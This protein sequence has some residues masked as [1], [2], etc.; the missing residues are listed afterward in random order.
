[1]ATHKVMIDVDSQGNFSYS[2]PVIVVNPGDKIKWKC[3]KEYWYGIFLKSYFS[4]LDK[5]HYVAGPKKEI[6]ARV[7]ASAPEGTY[8]YGVGVYNK[9]KLLLDDPE[10]IVERP[11]G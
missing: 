6:N 4:P 3:K 1:M 11:Q 10:I 7:L 2:D 8:P 5:K 9:K